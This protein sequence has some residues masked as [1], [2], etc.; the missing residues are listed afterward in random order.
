MKKQ[1]IFVIMTLFCL[2]AAAGGTFGYTNGEF[3]R[4][5]FMH[6]GNSKKQGQA[7]RLTHEKLVLL[8]GKKITGIQAIYGSRQVSDA[9]A[10]IRAELKGES[11][12][13][14]NF[15]VASMDVSSASAKWIETSFDSPYVIT[16][17]EKELFIGFMLEMNNANMNPLHVDYS[18]DVENSSFAIIDDEWQD[19]YGRGMGAVS[20]KAVLDDV[21]QSADLLMKRGYFSDY[22][23]AGGK[24]YFWGEVLNIGTES[25]HDFEIKFSAGTA[26][27]TIPFKGVNIE[28]GKTYNFELPEIEAGESGTSQMAME[29]TSVNGGADSDASDN[30]YSSNVFFYPE[31]MERNLLVEMFTGQDCSNCPAGHRTMNSVLNSTPYPHV[32]VIHHSG[33]HPDN[34]SMIE[35]YNYTLFFGGSQ[36]YAPAFMVARTP[37]PY[38]NIPVGMVSSDDVSYMLDYASNIRPF[39]SLKLD[40][41]YNPETR[42]VD[43]SFEVFP[44]EAFEGQTVMNV[45][46]VQDGL[47]DS[48]VNGG[49]QYSH[50]RAFRGT[51]TDN[52]WGMLSDF[53]VGEV[54]KYQKSFTLPETIKSTFWTEDY[55]KESGKTEEMVTK[56][57]VPENLYFVAYIAEYEEN[58]PT[59]NTVYNCLQVKLGESVAQAAFLSGASGIEETM[60]S[61]N[62]FDVNVIHGR[63]VVE[64]EVSGVSIFDASG[65]VCN[66]ALS[67]APGIYIVSAKSGGK[68]VVKKVVVR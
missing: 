53:K 48:Q 34:F 55:L 6:F 68:T 8:K 47:K 49:D 67:Q 19:I 14:K 65:R 27:Q 59:G 50:D 56:P 61:S 57:V 26:V 5:N 60:K 46:I 15:E 9:Q 12:V 62:T 33:Y 3:S 43:L 58:S 29:V 54:T 2:R 52:S 38:T 22:Y 39:A 20:L 13:T 51:V 23:K 17:E 45:M 16:G 40:T 44:H 10:F 36:P 64:G 7:I 32:E 42:V 21:P 30:G 31:N 35:D 11:I 4:N 25:V 1:L 24:Y 63:I 41:K 66:P 37:N 28:P 18:Y